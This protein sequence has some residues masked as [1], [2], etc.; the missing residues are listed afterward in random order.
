MQGSC[1]HWIWRK[2]RKYQL[3]LCN[4]FIP[5]FRNNINLQDPLVL[6]VLK[7]IQLL[8]SPSHLFYWHILI[9]KSTKMTMKLINKNSNSYKL[10]LSIEESG[11]SKFNLENAVCNHGFFMMPPNQWNP[12]TKSFRRPLRLADSITSVF[13]SICQ[14]PNQKFLYVEIDAR[15]NLISSLDLQAIQVRT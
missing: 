4:S 9:T 3:P 15:D 10:E 2:A 12:V 6:T 14:P 11:G 1:W 5:N 8:H 13:V 7:Q